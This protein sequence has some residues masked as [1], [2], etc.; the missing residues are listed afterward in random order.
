MLC[1]PEVYTDLRF[2]SIFRIPLEI[3]VANN[4]NLY[5]ETNDGGFLLS[6]F[7]IKFVIIKIPYLIS[8]N[9]LLT[10]GL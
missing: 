6:L 8:I 10:K 5:A 1:Y 7:W 4:I 2:V 9:S 3:C